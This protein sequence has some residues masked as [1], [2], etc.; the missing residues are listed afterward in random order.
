M[1]SESKEKSGPISHPFH[2]KKYAHED[3]KTQS[4][5]RRLIVLPLNGNEI[6]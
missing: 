1:I 2:A 5:L 4:V 3:M 6:M